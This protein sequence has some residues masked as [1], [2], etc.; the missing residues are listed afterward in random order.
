[1]KPRLT[2][3]QDKPEKLKENKVEFADGHT[4][5]YECTFDP[6]TGT[7]ITFTMS[8]ASKTPFEGFVSNDGKVIKWNDG[9]YWHKSTAEES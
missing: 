2:K 1:M 6:N 4:E 7:K 5:V 3:K 9:D 8:S